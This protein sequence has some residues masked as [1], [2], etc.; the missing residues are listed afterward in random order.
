[1]FL[2]LGLTVNVSITRFDSECFLTVNVSIT[3]FDS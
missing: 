2:L 3:R 1:M